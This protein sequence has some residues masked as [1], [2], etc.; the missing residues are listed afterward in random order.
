MTKLKR[1]QLEAQYTKHK[2]QRTEKRTIPVPEG[3][4]INRMRHKSEES[5][6]KVSESKSM[7]ATGMECRT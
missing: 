7:D 4:V 6:G 5:G 3:K 1:A 2:S